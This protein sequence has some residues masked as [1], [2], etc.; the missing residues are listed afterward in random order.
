MMMIIYQFIYFPISICYGYNNAASGFLGYDRRSFGQQD[1]QQ[2][3][4]QGCSCEA[5]NAPLCVQYFQYSSSSF[6]NASVD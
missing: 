5:R 6:E 3:Q 4:S 2:L 1:H